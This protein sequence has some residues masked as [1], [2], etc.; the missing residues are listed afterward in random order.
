M[1]VYKPKYYSQP[2]CSVHCCQGYVTNSKTATCEREYY[3][4]VINI[5]F[6]LLCV[7]IMYYNLLMFRYIIVLWWLLDIFLHTQA[8]STHTHI[9]V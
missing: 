2:V 5:I 6:S 1:E 3:I 4:P 9:H 8:Y 7:D